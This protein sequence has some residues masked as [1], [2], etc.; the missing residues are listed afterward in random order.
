MTSLH[1][2]TLE[3][4]DW[5]F[6]AE[7]LASHARTPAGRALASSVTLSGDVS[8]IEASFDSID[9][10]FRLYE[11]RVGA[12]P[13]GGIEPIGAELDRAARGEVLAAS[14]IAYVASTLAA[15][16][17]LADFLERHGRDAP[18]LAG[19]GEPVS[20]DRRLCRTFAAAIDEHGQLSEATYPV[21]GELRRR[22]ASLERSIR[23]T[24]EN[25]LDSP[26]YADVLQDRYVTVRGDRFVVPVKSH[27]RN[28][29]LGIV[30][31][32]SRSER[33]VFVEPASIVPI[34]NERR[35]AESALADEERRILAELSAILG[36]HAGA[37][38][39]ALEA[40]AALDLA[41]ART[42][43][44][45]RLDARRPAVGTDG[46]IALDRARHPVLA[47]AAPSVVA[48]DLRLDAARPVL[49][50]TGPNAGG[51]TVAMKAIGLCA[52]LVRAGCFVP[53]REG[54]RVDV[55]DPVLADIG[56]MQTVHEGL[57]SFSAHLA[58]LVSMIAASGRGTL[59][60]L[61]EIAAG[62]DPAQGGALARAIVE[63]FADAGARIVATTHY[64]QVKR[65]GADDPRVEVAALEYADGKPTY[66]VVA[67]SIGESH[68]LAAADRAGIG[69]AIIERARSLMDAG[70]RALADT[71]AALENEKSEAA[72]AHARADELV[73]SLEDRERAVAARE[74]EVRGRAKEAERRAASKLVDAL[75]AAEQDVRRAV[76]QLREDASR[77]RAD[78]ARVAIAAARK[79]VED[80]RRDEASQR[81]AKPGDRV[82]VAGVG[83][84][85]DVVEIRDG[86]LEIRAGSMT[87]RAKPDEVE[88]VSGK[89]PAP[90]DPV[91]MRARKEPKRSPT[92]EDWLDNAFRMPA[93]T[94]DLRG[95]RV[96]E[97]IERLEAFLDESMLASR[98]YVFVLHGHG[99]GAM[100]SAVR[101]AL[102]D[103]PYVSAS[104]PA[105]E[106]QGGD[107]LTVSRLRG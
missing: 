80:A 14:E 83:L 100:K 48:N 69:G 99:S 61:D 92:S 70:E 88:V 58:T 26:E 45:H 3:V 44:A 18:T 41:C 107:A 6:V 47:L 95:V 84:V 59:L 97:G 63:R 5:P 55:F 85:G 10:I 4:L 2:R 60:L 106:D 50:L 31:D 68:A 13:V 62:T 29:G 16:S 9:E 76:T 78:A 49:V 39:A 102:A 8:T 28:L 38:R 43:F 75:R 103:S 77:E 36:E 74:E 65:M 33:T 104:A 23:T 30:H 57:S 52:L 35:I 32:A 91:P 34:G 89:R 93:N 11:R 40:A 1:Q 15:L 90:G 96:D 42:D 66:R 71:L 101:R 81:E 20:P 72:R 46:T 53:A 98:E 56:D 12:P 24:L 27:A 17:A 73:R 87:L 94:L 21:L 37:L 7:A 67:G 79:A 64:T 25:L 19:I 105:P 51:K 22:I 82:R 86:Q 54:S